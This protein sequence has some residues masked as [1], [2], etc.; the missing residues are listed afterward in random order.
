MKR[1]ICIIFLTVFVFSISV[2]CFASDR[3]FSKYHEDKITKSFKVKP[4]QLLSL[5]SDFGSVEIESWDRNEVK[6]VVIKEMD[7]RNKRD[8]KEAFEYFDISFDQN[9]KG[10]KIIGEYNGPKRWFR[11]NRKLKIHFDIIVPREFD[12]DIYTAGGSIKAAELKGQID[13]H[14][15][16]GSID[17][18][19]IVGPLNVNTSGGR[20]DVYKV[21]GNIDVHTSGGSISLEKINGSADA[22]TSGGTIVADD[23]NG[24]TYAHSSGGSLKLRNINGNVN[25]KTS[26]GSI[27]AELTKEITRDCSFKTSGGSI[28]VYLPKRIS[29]EV[30]AYTSG[31][32]VSTDLPIAV[33]G[34]IKKNSLNG[35]INDGG[36]LI[37]LRTSGGSISLKEL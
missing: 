16:G 11:S 20:I 21:D 23:I 37:Y 17:V 6:I 18:E 7:T 9:R 14:T 1:I 19:Q 36:P 30:D 28:Q 3:S 31:G 25:A 13:L 4:G 2:G 12:V 10:V 29:A 35:E 24:D 8:A 15:S 26:G 33:R 32:R 5:K 34:K 22:K 27:Y